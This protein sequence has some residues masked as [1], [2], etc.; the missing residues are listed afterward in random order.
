MKKSETAA[1]IVLV[2]ALIYGV[3]WMTLE[4]RDWVDGFLAGY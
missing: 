2:A 4:L 1:I 3:G